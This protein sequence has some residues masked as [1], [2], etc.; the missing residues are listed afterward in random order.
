MGD[1]LARK[2]TRWRNSSISHDNF[3]N[4]DNGDDNSIS[5]INSSNNIMTTTATITIMTSAK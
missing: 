4:D 2:L 1:K 3:K 5:N